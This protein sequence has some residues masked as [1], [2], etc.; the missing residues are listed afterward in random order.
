V[1][2]STDSQQAVVRRS[3][4]LRDV[5]DPAYTRLNVDERRRQLLDA[6]RA[7]FAEHAYEEI[8]MQQ[9]ATVAGISKP[10]LY[11]YFPNKA[12]LFKTAVAE[13]AAELEQL[14]QPTGDGPP[15]QQLSDSLDGYLEWIETHARTWQKLVQSAAT[16][17]EAGTLVDQFRS[18]TLQQIAA[19][20]TT[21]EPRPALRN[22]LRGWLGYVDAAILDWISDGGLSREQLRNMLLASF[23]AALLSAQQ[24]DPEIQIVLA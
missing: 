7:L 24:A 19:R 4:R 15:V 21:G 1:S 12:E 6:G 20:L 17:P 13:H 10:L 18:R 3:I 11:H 8:S 2:L 16:L 23:G 5:S 22:A 9:I 14:L